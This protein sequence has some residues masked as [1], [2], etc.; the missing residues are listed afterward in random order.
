MMNRTMRGSAASTRTPSA[1]AGPIR[2]WSGSDTTVE[3]AHTSVGMAPQRAS[4]SLALRVRITHPAPMSMLCAMLA[5][6]VGGCAGHKPII[7]APPR[8]VSFTSADGRVTATIHGP[9]R[10]E[11]NRPSAQK[12]LE[13]FLYGPEDEPGSVL[14]RPQGLTSAG[15]FLYIADQGLPDV[16]RYDLAG[17]TYHRWIRSGDRPTCPIAA[18]ADDAGRVYV[19]DA[20]KR[21]VFA[22]DEQGHREADLSL[23]PDG[24]EQFRPSAIL[25]HGGVVYVADADSQQIRCFDLARHIWITPIG[26]GSADDAVAMPAGL[27]MTPRGELLVTDA[28][29]GLVH[30]FDA[31]GKPLK[32]IGEYGAETGQLIRPLGI[33]CTTSGIILVADAGRESVMAFDRDGAFLFE[34]AGPSGEWNGFFMPTGVAVL[35]G[36][37]SITNPG[38]DTETAGGS[39]PEWAVVSDTMHG[40]LTLLSIQRT[41]PG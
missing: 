31:E 17:R 34:I 30:R 11:P 3:H 13:W 8:P 23:H 18:A 6:L 36:Y 5:V 19:A 33:A 22:F 1:S 27:A 21:T 41:S 35:P 26:P 16:L 29:L 4:P 15:G 9:L 40:T 38:D 24:K 2:A 12:R 7:P 20:A 14:R 32:P 10:R 39:Q 37:E 28:I 25:V